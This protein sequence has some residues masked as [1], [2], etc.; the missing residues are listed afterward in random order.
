MN[1]TTLHADEPEPEDEPVHVQG[2]DARARP[3]VPA[4]QKA[5]CASALIVA[6]HVPGLVLGLGLVHVKL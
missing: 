5:S 6:G 3:N 1:A 4:R 2:N